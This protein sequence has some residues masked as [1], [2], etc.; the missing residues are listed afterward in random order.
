MAPQLKFC[1]ACHNE[2]YDSDRCPQCDSDFIENV[3]FP[4][5]VPKL[6]LRSRVQMTQLHSTMMIT[7][8]MHIMKTIHTPPLK[9]PY[10][11]FHM[12]QRSSNNSR[13]SKT[14]DDS[15][16][17]QHTL[18]MSLLS[19]KNHSDSAQLNRIIIPHPVQYLILINRRIRCS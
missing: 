4:S 10:Q 13:N 1:H 18:L 19:V 2:F 3:R 14:L 11:L 7:M 5:H 16:L 6:I 17:V 12:L 15:A 9:C 8:V